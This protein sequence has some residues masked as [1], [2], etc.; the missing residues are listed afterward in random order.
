MNYVYDFQRPS[1]TVDICVVH[2][3]KVL[4]IQRK[5]EPFKDYW[6]FPGGFVEIGKNEIIIEAAVRELREETN[7]W[8]PSSNFI[9]VDYYDEPKRD[10]TRGRVIDFLF[11]VRLPR[12]FDIS[13][14][15]ASD[16]AANAKWY[17][18]EDLYDKCVP[19]AFDHQK[20]IWQ[21]YNKYFSES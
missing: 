10:S 14:I 16:D 4:L 12:S 8:L 5:K 9:F 15:K 7:L 20:M 1:I 2:K 3:G 21:V 19:L 11:L 18:L 6:A 13:E 17:P